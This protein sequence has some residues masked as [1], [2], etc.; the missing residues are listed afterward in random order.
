MEFY[1]KTQGSRVNLLLIYVYVLTSPPRGTLNGG[2]VYS[3]LYNGHFKEPGAPLESGA[4]SV[5][6]LEPPLTPLGAES[7]KTT[8]KL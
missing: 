5:F 2:A 8:H 4:P 7:T 3:V 1:T 6:L